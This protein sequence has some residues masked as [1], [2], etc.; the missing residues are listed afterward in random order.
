MGNLNYAIDNVLGNEGMPADSGIFDVISRAAV[1]ELGFGKLAVQGQK[2]VEC[3]ISLAGQ[4]VVTFSGNLVTS[5]V[6]NAKING[7]AINPVTFATDNATTMA[8]IA[9]A[10]ET[11]D[12]GV[13]ATV[14]SANVL[15]VK[16]LN[17]AS[18][19]TDVVV[20]LGAGQAT[21]TVALSLGRPVLGVTQYDGTR[22]E[23]LQDKKQLFRDKDAVSIRRKGRII[24]KPEQ[25]VTP[26]SPVFVRIN[27][28]G[29]IGGFRA[30]NASGN[31]VELATGFKYMTT[32]DS[33]GF[34]VLE[35]NL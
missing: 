5:N 26:E 25:A 28:T 19:I 4:S 24:V 27:G 18:V 34:V 2:D 31:A 22:Q 30:D 14:T 3:H 20:T 9:E 13:E 7:V 16:G 11:A 12:P 29:E 10:I 32:R 6:V 21:A 1:G 15:T 35:V 8:A 23:G 17:Q 33:N